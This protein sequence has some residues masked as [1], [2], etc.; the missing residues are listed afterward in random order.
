MA[1]LSLSFLLLGSSKATYPSWCAITLCFF[2]SQFCDSIKVL[3][4]FVANQELV[5]SVA[6]LVS[7]CEIV[8]YWHVS[9]KRL[10]LSLSIFSLALCVFVCHRCDVGTKAL[11]PLIFRDPHPVLMCLHGGNYFIDLCTTVHDWFS[12]ASSMMIKVCRSSSL[13]TRT[14]LWIWQG[15]YVPRHWIWSAFRQYATDTTCSE[16]G[17]IDSNC[18]G[19]IPYWL[20][21]HTVI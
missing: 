1:K 4:S 3:G 15:N 21:A 10:A 8:W 7:F 2:P 14:S 13:E 5:L 12:Q 11:F 6:E 18:D 20:Y 16:S 17:A 19:F 9:G